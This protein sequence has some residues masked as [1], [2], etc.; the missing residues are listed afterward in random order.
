MDII[1]LVFFILSGPSHNKT[2]EYLFLSLNVKDLKE[3]TMAE[4]LMHIPNVDTQNYPFF[5]ADTFGHLPICR[6]KLDKSS[7][8]AK[9]TNKKS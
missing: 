8:I 6:N 3:K 9:P 5:V 4:K 2:T 7:H 1:D